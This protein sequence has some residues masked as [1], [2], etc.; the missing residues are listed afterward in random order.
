L[1]KEIFVRRRY[2]WAF[3]LVVFAGAVGAGLGLAIIGGLLRATL[4]FGGGLVAWRL[5]V[6]RSNEQAIEETG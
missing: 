5:R 1:W 4:W 6:G 2:S 3:P